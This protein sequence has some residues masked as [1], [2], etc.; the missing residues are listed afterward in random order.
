MGN[1]LYSDDVGK[2]CWNAA[3]TWQIGW[4]DS[5][6]IIIDPKAQQFWS[7]TIVGIADF[8]NN[9][10]QYPVVVK[11]ETGTS[12]DQFIN[13]N[14]AKGVN[15]QNDEA[16]N[17]VT[18]VETGSNGEGYSQS[19]L[20]AHL[21]QGEVYTYVNWAGTG[22]N[23]VVTA[24]VINI[25]TGST[26]YAEVTVCLGVCTPDPT[27]APTV[28]P[29]SAP[30]VA[31][32]N[33][34]TAAPT[35]SPTASP[36]SSPTP[37]PT[38]SPTAPPTPAPTNSPE[39]T[40]SPTSSPTSA[41]TD[42][43]TPGPTVPPTKAPTASPTVAPTASPTAS[44]TE[45]PTAAPTS[46]PTAGP[47]VSPTEA[48]TPVPTE[49]PTPEPTALPTHTPTSS[50]TVPPTPAPTRAPTVPSVCDGQ[51]GKKKCVSAAVYCTW[52]QGNCI[53]T[54]MVGACSTFVRGRCNQE[55]GCVWNQSTNA[56]DNK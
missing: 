39:P 30:T 15:S 22:Q 27:P 18:I 7:G 21:V 55:G 3:K 20:K 28:P 8:D 16:D 41:P 38:V 45:A 52:S 33:A 29:T 50:P 34:P 11:I 12:T 10:D 31:Q 2:M 56:C 23:L 47:T 54:S 43:P 1:P 35:S 46:A 6:K 9:P 13:F 42:A 14:R 49:A 51:Q 26:D 37:Q 19:Y 44:P 53:D 24:N 25:S 4:Y 5:N 36:T 48:P 17:E 32:T 40:A